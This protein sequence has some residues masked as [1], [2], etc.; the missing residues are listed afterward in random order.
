MTSIKSLPM[1]IAIASLLACAGPQINLR[2]GTARA[3]VVN[4]PG[5]TFTLTIQQAGATDLTLEATPDG[6]VVTFKDDR[7]KNLNPAVDVTITMT[8][9]APPGSECPLAGNTYRVT[10]RLTPVSG[11]NDTYNIAL[12]AFEQIRTTTRINGGT[13]TGGDYDTARGVGVGIYVALDG[14]ACRATCW[15]QWI[16]T[17]IWAT[18]GT[19]TRRIDGGGNFQ[20]AFGHAQVYGQFGRDLNIQ[21]PTDNCFQLDPIPGEPGRTGI[22]DLPGQLP[23]NANAAAIR[24]A[25]EAR[26]AALVPPMA[27]SFPYTVQ[28]RFTARSVLWCTDPAPPTILGSFAWSS[29]DTWPYQAGGVQ[30]A[31]AVTARPAWTPGIGTLPAPMQQF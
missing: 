18:Q 23:T 22:L 31:R 21:T 4:C 13:V 3:G 28:W 24:A 26:M 19:D 17:E 1:F 16:S 10:Q 20:D 12:D 9:R 14:T 8:V 30:P 27:T 7:I 2:D 15:Q 29:T 6:D 5:A 11:S 25:S